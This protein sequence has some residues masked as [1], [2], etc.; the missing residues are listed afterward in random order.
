[1]A[2][3]K[4]TPT[5]TFEYAHVEEWTAVPNPEEPGKWLFKPVDVSPHFTFAM[6]EEWPDRVYAD[7]YVDFWK[8]VLDL[9]ADHDKPVTIKMNVKYMIGQE[10]EEKIRELMEEWLQLGLGYLAVAQPSTEDA[11][12]NFVYLNF[13]E[14]DFTATPLKTEEV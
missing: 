3:K 7:Y 1:M 10:T 5:D 13:S 8:P 2:K 12:P 14:A 6:T 11:L 9:L 4:P